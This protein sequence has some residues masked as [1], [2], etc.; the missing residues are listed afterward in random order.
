MVVDLF[1]GQGSAPGCLIREMV[2]TKSLTVTV[3]R[4][5]ITPEEAWFRLELSGAASAIDRFV[6]RS[7]EG[8]AILPS[9]AGVLA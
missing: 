9:P 8:I 5:R 7:R 6:T 3:L 4:G 1:A 2:P